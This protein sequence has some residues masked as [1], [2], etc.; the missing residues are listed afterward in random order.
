MTLLF[1]Y[2]L[3]KAIH[4]AVIL[5]L[6]II[7]AIWLTQSL[8]FIEVIVNHNVNLGGYFSLVIY[9]IPDL[10]ALVMPICL[11]ISGIQLFH[12]MKI[13]HELHVLRALGLSNLRISGPL[14]L[15]SLVFM[16]TIYWINIFVMPLSFKK[17]RDQEYAIRNQFSSALIR[18]GSFNFMKG[19]TVF[20]KERSLDGKLNDVFI[21]KPEMQKNG[22]G[23]TTT[24]LAKSGSFYKSNN[25]YSMVLKQGTR[26]E[27]DI[28]TKNVSF[29]GFDEFV[30][31][32]SKTLQKQEARAVKPYEKSLT[33]LFSAQAEKYDKTTLARMRTEGHQ[34]LLTP[35]LAVVDALLVC[36]LMLRQ[37][38]RRKKSRF[39]IAA[40]AISSLL[41]HLGVV[42]LLN[43][44]VQTPGLIYFLYAFIPILMMGLLC[45]L[46][47]KRLVFYWR[48]L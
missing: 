2:I 30:Y 41:I 21:F 33:E 3:F 17:F 48:N 13:D 7:G 42:A 5:L 37:S 14:L 31:D 15:L 22:V 18:E 47:W 16:A 29:F 6:I 27:K 24:I 8:R 11:L 10:V 1:R 36:A 4:V 39:V 25:Q 40:V 19:M 44:S 23:K 46:E 28:S 35:W 34:R 43:L 12:K 9:L 38:M 20:I 32:F 45:T 26:Q